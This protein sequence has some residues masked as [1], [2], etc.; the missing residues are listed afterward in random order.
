MKALT[1]KDKNSVLHRHN[2]EAHEGTTP[3][4]YMSVDRCHDTALHRQ[5]TEAVKINN[6]PNVINNKTEWASQN[7]VRVQLTCD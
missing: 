1:K 5:I 6:T 4:Y 2:I 3:S 7:T